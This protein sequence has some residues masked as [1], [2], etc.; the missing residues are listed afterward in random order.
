MSLT[1]TILGC[2]SS[3]GV[4]RVGS[5]W[6][7]CDPAKPAEPPPALLDPGR[8]RPEPDGARRS[9]STRRRTCATSSRARQVTRLDGVLYTHAHA[10]HTHGID[11]LRP[12]VIKMRRVLPVYMDERHVRARA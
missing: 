5:G 6:G 11:D 1:F 8:A 7:A 3:G 10:D 4:P 2:G 9:S 12:L